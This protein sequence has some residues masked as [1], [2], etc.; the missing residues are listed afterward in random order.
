MNLRGIVLAGGKSSR[1][2]EDKALVRI[3]ERPLL[4]RTVDLI[5]SLGLPVAVIANPPQ[6]YS[7]VRCPVHRDAV[8]GKGPMGGLYTA[9]AQYPGACLL[10]LTCDM[11]GMTREILEELAGSRD[12]RHRAAVFSR[13]G[14]R[15]AGGLPFPGLYEAALE[16]LF[17]AC[18][19]EDRLS[20]R[21]FLAG[22]P[23]LRI[24]RPVSEE[25]EREMFFNLNEKE[26]LKKFE[27]LEKE[28]LK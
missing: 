18:L 10:V 6:D 1:F 2:G 16:N 28:N 5:R 4:E 12:G 3:G 26:D 20:M 25:E 7:F 17:E 15:E 22:L 21:D 27:Q 13:P 11:P 8:S 24:V 9:C 14:G 23:D 19:R